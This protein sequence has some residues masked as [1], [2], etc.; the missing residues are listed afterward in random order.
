MS[1]QHEQYLVGLDLSGRRVVVVGGG[2]VAQRRVAR[3][4]AVGALV[5]VVSPEVT[6]AVEGMV[7]AGEITW[8]ARRYAEGDLTGAWYVIAATDD[9]AVNETVTA[10]AERDRV[11]CVRADD[12]SRGTA[13]TPATGA[14]DGL[15]VGVLARGAHRRSSAVRTALVEALQSGVVDENAEPPQPG[16]ALVGGGPGDP[17]LITVRGRRLL[18]RAQVVVTDRLGPRD[19]MDE[20]SPDVEVIDASKI[21]YGRAMA[22]E[23]I[24]ELLVEHARAGKF[25]VRLKGGDPFVYGRGFE[26]VQACAAAG[27]PVTVVPGIT[28]AFAAPAVA[29][30]PVTHRG[31]AHEIVVVSG[32]VAPEDPRSLTDWAA[33]GRMTG[34]I[35]LMM[36]VERLARFAEVLV[37]HGRDPQTPVLIV[38]D[39]TTRIQRTV[40][41]TLETAGR[42]AAEEDV[43]PPAI[44]VIGPVAGLEAP[45]GS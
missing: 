3:L 12:G 14:H 44:V 24:N 10:D 7:S 13:V 26:E 15:T 23:K 31:V 33:L 45:V 35:V 42:V 34:T 40:R 25:V 22:Q 30:T 6:P 21:P 28:S 43:N 11:F 32:H 5:E 38:Q 39:G 9:A 37:E 29:G 20:L 2:Q 1:A 19:L 8:T 4:I 18:S 27:V 16:V 17:E 36:A 41:A